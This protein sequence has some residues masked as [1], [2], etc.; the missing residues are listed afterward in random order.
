[1][2]DRAL[3]IRQ[4]HVLGYVADA[5]DV[6][7][8]DVADGLRLAPSTARDILRALEA[9][10]LVRPRYTGTRNGLIEWQATFNGNALAA[11]LFRDDEP[12]EVPW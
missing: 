2:A 8:I 10:G 5:G 12:E 6:S 11:D 1:M 4:R 3:T 7:A 9:R